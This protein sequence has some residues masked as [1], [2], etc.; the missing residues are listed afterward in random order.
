MKYLKLLTVVALVGLMAALAW[1]VPPASG[2][3]EEAPTYAK[4]VKPFLQTYCINCHGANKPK[5]GVN[6][7]GYDL[8]VNGGKKLIKVGQPDDS[9]LCQVCE[10]KGKPMPPKRSK[11]P[12]AEEIKAVRAWIA[13][14]AKN[15]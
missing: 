10:G 7:D 6:L 4:T 2:A 5:A 9:R 8:V 1:S 12:T 3:D 11:Q 14:G 15:N 13:D